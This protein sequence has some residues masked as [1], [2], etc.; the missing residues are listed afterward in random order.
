M[1]ETRAIATLAVDVGRCEGPVACRDGSTVFVSLDHGVVYRLHEGETSRLAVTGGGPNGAA[2][3]CDGSIYVAQNGGKPPARYWPFVTGGVQIVRRSGRVDWLTQDPVS[4]N[5]ICFGPDG[6]LWL[7]DPTRRRPARDDG[8]LWRC[9]PETGEAELLVSVPWYPNGI[10]F[11]PEDD[12]VYV[13]STG[14]ARIVRFPLAGGRLGTP[15]VFARMPHGM[16]DGLAFDETGNLL[17]AA[18]SPGGDGDIQTFD[19]DGRLLDLF[20]PGPGPAYTNLALTADRRLLIT[21]SENHRL[22]EVTGWPAAGLPLHPFRAAA[23]GRAPER[24]RR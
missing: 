19:R 10:A 22:L 15:E 12:A 2:E 16:P 9:D 24:S 11:G 7:T 13:A 6:A 1:T 4:P 5:D 20:Q 23:G 3:G 18:G 8:R 21:D 17:V 14:D